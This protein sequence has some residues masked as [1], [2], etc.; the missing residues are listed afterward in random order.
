MRYEDHNNPLRKK[1]PWNLVTDKLNT[2]KSV[3][4]VEQK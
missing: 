1:K 4:A 2:G 3:K